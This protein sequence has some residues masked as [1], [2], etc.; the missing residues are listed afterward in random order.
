M[1]C[2]LCRG[3]GINPKTHH[4]YTCGTHDDRRCPRCDGVGE[5]EEEML[6]VYTIYDH[7][8]DHPTK[9]VLRKSLAGSVDGK[10]TVQHTNEYVCCDPLE[11]ARR[12]VPPGLYCMPRQP[13]DDPVI[14][15]SWL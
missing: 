2:N 4:R 7:P 12:Y 13:E 8:K 15:E 5:E 11:E 10:A 6:S 9:F 1:K 3:S 14:I